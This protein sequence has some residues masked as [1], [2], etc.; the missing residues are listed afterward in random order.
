[1]KTSLKRKRQL[2]S[3]RAASAKERRLKTKKS[4]AR[5]S[6]SRAKTKDLKKK[7]RWHAEEENW[8]RGKVLFSRTVEAVLRR[9]SVCP[10]GVGGGPQGRALPADRLI[11]GPRDSRSRNRSGMRALRSTKKGLTFVLPEAG[12]GAAAETKPQGCVSPEGG[13]ELPAAAPFPRPRHSLG[14]RQAGSG[15]LGFSKQTTQTAVPQLSDAMV[16]PGRALSACQPRAAEPHVH[17]H[18]C[19]VSS[20]R[21]NQ[22]AALTGR[23]K[24]S[25]DPTHCSGLRSR[26]SMHSI[27]SRAHCPGGA[28]D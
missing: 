11:A 8:S 12:Q 21:T 25:I 22:R 19:P 23:Q 6:F 9:V 20:T 2:T 26:K 3:A 5:R 13:T 1:M 15:I 4:T 7:K 16:S 10:S 17:A 24:Q 27:A 18:C 28:P 14:T